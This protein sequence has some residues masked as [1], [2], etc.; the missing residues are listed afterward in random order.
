MTTGCSMLEQRGT[1]EYFKRRVTAEKQDTGVLLKA[2][3]LK[4]KVR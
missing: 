3:C 1:N 4:E 2:I